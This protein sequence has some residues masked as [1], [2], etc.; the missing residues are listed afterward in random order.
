[1][2]KKSVSIRDIARIAG[3]STATVSKVLN[4]KGSISKATQ[5]R[6]MNIAQAQGYVASYAARTLREGTTHTIG[7]VVPDVSN[8]FYS[9]IV[10]H[11]E[12]L[13]Y[14]AGYT[15][16]IC[17]TANNIERTARYV[18]SLVQRQVDG[19]VFVNG[20]ALFDLDQ[21][22]AELPVVIL[23]PSLPVARPLTVRVRNDLSAIVRDNIH[24]LAARGCTRIALLSVYSGTGDPDMGWM[25][26]QQALE[27][28]GLAADLNLVLAGPHLKESRIEAAELVGECLDAGHAPDGIVCMGDRV[29][30]GACEALRERGIT[31]G[32]EIKVIGM[33]DSLFARVSV[34]ALS[35]VRRHE[36]EIARRGV[37]AMLSMLAGETP[38]EDSIVVPH[39][40]IER[41][42]TLG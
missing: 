39:E 34:P 42:S 23:D 11:A 27:E 28:V 16:Y 8:P 4:G 13:L 32:S 24:T 21:L 1:M 38:K 19:L 33:D 10:Q 36:D 30:L 29:A 31:I 22:P 5:E 6:V 14:D 17:D 9:A 26:Y 3:V 25:G 35:S 15:C 2:P 12:T 37:E 20:H 40:V 18:D 7:I 41:E